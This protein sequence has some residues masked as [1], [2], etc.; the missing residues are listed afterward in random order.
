MTADLFTRLAHRAI[1]VV[2]VTMQPAPEP[3]PVWDEGDALELATEVDAP[4]A[5]GAPPAAGAVRFPAPLPSAPVVAGPVPGPVTPVLVPMPGPPADPVPG[6]PV[7]ATP[8]SALASAVAPPPLPDPADVN[9][10]SSRADAGT[11]QPRQRTGALEPPPMPV[12]G[13]PARAPERRSA[14]AA[15]PHTSVEVTVGRIEIRVRPPAHEDTGRPRAGVGPAPALP[16]E[17]YLRRRE[18]SS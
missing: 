15:T 12:I 10:D 9:S 18:A 2:G 6:N 11:E 14:P 16:L 8:P 4:P 5:T 17:E 1:G 7:L 13:P 3:E